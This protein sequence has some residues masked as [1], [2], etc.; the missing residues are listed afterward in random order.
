MAMNGN[1]QD[2][3]VEIFCTRV[4]REMKLQKKRRVE[5]GTNVSYFIHFL[6]SILVRMRFI[7]QCQIGTEKVCDVALNV[8]FF[9]MILQASRVCGLEKFK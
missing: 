1:I 2:F 7:W 5:P 3:F 9:N 6:N 4:D 8:D